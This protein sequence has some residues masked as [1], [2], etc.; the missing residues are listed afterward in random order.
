MRPNPQLTPLA[1]LIRKFGTK[2]E[3]GGY[4]VVLSP[5]DFMKI[6]QTGV[7]H[8]TPGEQGGVRWQ[9]FP[10]PTVEGKEAGLK[11]EMMPDHAQGYSDLGGYECLPDCAACKLDKALADA[12]KEGP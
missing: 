2:V 5:A 12:K 8:E 10:S 3:G 11:G 1:V 4:E 6:T 9:Y 7:F